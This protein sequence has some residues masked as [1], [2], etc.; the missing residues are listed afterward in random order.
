M[1]DK[2][3]KENIMQKRVEVYNPL[4]YRNIKQLNPYYPFRIFARS[5]YDGDYLDDKYINI[6]CR[7]MMHYISIPTLSVNEC[8]FRISDHLDNIKTLYDLFDIQH[9]D[10]SNI[11]YTDRSIML[12]YCL[13]DYDFNI[14]KNVIVRAFGYGNKIDGNVEEDIIS[15]LNKFGIGELLW[16]D[17]YDKFM[18]DNYKVHYDSYD[19]TR[20][21]DIDA[22][23]RLGSEMKYE[24][25]DPSQFPF[26][27]TI[28]NAVQERQGT[29]F[30]VKHYYEVY[31]R[32]AR[33]TA[34]EK[35]LK[36]TRRHPD[37]IKVEDVQWLV[38]KK[39]P[40]ELIQREMGFDN[41]YALKRYLD[42]HNINY[43]ACKKRPG[44]PRGSFKNTSARNQMYE[45]FAIGLVPD[46]LY[47]KYKGQY[48]KRSIDRIYKEWKED[49]AGFKR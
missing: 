14:T 34:Q 44:R 28:F 38:D 33:M 25:G 30:I 32:V 12:A 8:A 43:E 48:S 41:R 17:D 13:N 20:R 6:I 2:L 24:L 3:N 37:D 27:N 11:N 46:T 4:Q 45:D 21:K 7:F 36:S 9:I 40:L 16:H 49:Q 18:Y 42:K 22:V 47:N 31:E 39:W 5:R 19:G 35:M 1:L 23:E 29:N 26:K 10:I 15:S